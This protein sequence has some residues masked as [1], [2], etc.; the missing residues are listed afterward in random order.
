MPCTNPSQVVPEQWA[1]DYGLDVNA[2]QLWTPR[3]F[4][5]HQSPACAMRNHPGAKYVFVLREPKDVLVSVWNFF[6]TEART[7]LMP[8]TDFRDVNE[9]AESSH[10]REFR[11]L[12]NGHIWMYI[13]Q[14]WEARR[15]PGVLVLFYEDLKD[16][17]EGQVRP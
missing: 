8:G 10:W 7:S 17:P 9:F 3:V 16:S 12:F 14:A 2:P 6:H 1:Y 5:A 15:H 13:K 4:K 11:W